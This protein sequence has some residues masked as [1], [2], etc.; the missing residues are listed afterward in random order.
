M[1]VHGAK[2]LEAPIVI[3]AD[4]CGSSA[5]AER[6][7]SLPAGGEKRVPAWVP[8]I[9]LDCA[10]T[11][12]RASRRSGKPG[13]RGAPPALRRHDARPRPADRR[14]MPGER[15]GAGD[16]LV[17][18]G[19]GRACREIPSGPRRSS[20]PPGEEPVKRWRISARG[21]RRARDRAPRARLAGARPEW[22]DRAAPR[23]PVAQPPLRPS[24]A[25]DAAEER[26]APGLYGEPRRLARRPLRPCAARAFARHPARTARRGGGH[27]R[28]GLDGGLTRDA[29]TRSPR[30]RST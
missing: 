18:D 24:S 19:E 21:R 15:Q 3:L 29:A 17:H 9:E 5:G 22:L 10:A 12:R 27:S 7:L 14:G 1:T 13:A 8:R 11:A 2:G 6:L 26:G 25:L 30:K 23:E 20:A 16:L 4:A 28:A